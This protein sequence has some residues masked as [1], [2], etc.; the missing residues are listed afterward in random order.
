[1]TIPNLLKY[2]D[3]YSRKSGHAPENIPPRTEENRT[4]ENKSL[5]RNKREALKTATKEPTKTHLEKTRHAEFKDAIHAYWKSKNPD[6]PCPWDGAE[7]K[8]LAM[9]MKSAPG[10]TTEQFEIFL[11]NRYRSE[12][13][14][15]GERPSRWIR[16]ITQFANGPLN[17][18]KQPIETKS[19]LDGMSMVNPEDYR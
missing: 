18:F 12:A 15:H 9:W 3:D 2:R 13:V 14:N 7:G 10:V 4:E 17:K 16:N 11:R 1:V 19:A 6:V 8:H 5:S